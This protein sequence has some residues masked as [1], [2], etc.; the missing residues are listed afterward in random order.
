MKRGLAVIMILSFALIASSCQ[1]G[2]MIVLGASDH[3][4]V[5]G[6]V[7]GNAGDI[8]NVLT[9]PTV[10]QVLSAALELPAISNSTK[11]VI[12]ITLDF[13]PELGGWLAR[14]PGETLL[15]IDEIMSNVTKLETVTA[16]T[17]FL[18]E[19]VNSGEYDGYEWLHKA[20]EFGIDL[21]EAGANTI[22]NPGWYPYTQPPLNS[23][24]NVSQLWREDLQGG[25]EGAV[26]CALAGIAPGDY[27]VGIG[28]VVGAV[29]SSIAEFISQLAD[30]W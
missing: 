20:L 8:V 14:I 28:G 17:S 18:Q 12:N 15:A 11:R 10:Q 13:L 23:S 30:Q 24:F 21:L 22:Y 26:G 4:D 19:V 3:T 27:G 25:I 2:G 5:M 7:V 1:P 9:I 29:N 6:G 16:T